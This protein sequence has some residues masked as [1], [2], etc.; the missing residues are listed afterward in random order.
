MQFILLQT[1]SCTIIIRKD[2]QDFIGK[3]PENTKY[4]GTE[5]IITW[6]VNRFT[7]DHSIVAYRKPE[8]SVPKKPIYFKSFTTG[9]LEN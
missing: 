5:I 4:Y 2:Y 7:E 8:E 3:H 1:N 9:H 6:D